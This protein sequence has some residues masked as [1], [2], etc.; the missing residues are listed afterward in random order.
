MY[1]TTE[2]FEIKGNTK[3]YIF[4]KYFLW[5]EQRF[6]LIESN[7]YMCRA[8]RKYLGDFIVPHSFIF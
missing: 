6:I 7:K 4:Q 8:V 2:N 3:N 5:I 1:K